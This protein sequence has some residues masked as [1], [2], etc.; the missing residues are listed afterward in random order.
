VSRRT[1]RVILRRY[2]AELAGPQ[3]EVV[4]ER[5]G[6][7]RHMRHPHAHRGRRGVLLIHPDDVGDVVASAESLGLR[8]EVVDRDGDPVLFG[9][10]LLGGAA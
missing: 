3:L 9:G 4:L 5:A 2:E 8:V 6:V 10:L 1:V 7:E